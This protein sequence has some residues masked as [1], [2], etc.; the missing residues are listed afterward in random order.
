MV[1]LIRYSWSKATSKAVENNGLMALIS[2]LQAVTLARAGVVWEIT[3]G[4]TIP[5]NDP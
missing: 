4:M 3:T 5:N 2:P 1:A